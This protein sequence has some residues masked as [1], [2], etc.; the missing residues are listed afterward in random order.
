[1]P[2]TDSRQAR[3]GPEDPEGLSADFLIEGHSAV[4]AILAG[5]C[6][7]RERLSLYAAPENR[8]FAITRILRVDDAEVEIDL[9]GQDEFA[10][11]LARGGQ[12]IGVAFPGQIKIQ[13]SLDE[14]SVLSADG[15]GGP[16]LRAPL[17]V[18]LHRFQRRDAFRVRPPV[19]DEARCVRILGPDREASHPICDIS[20]GGLSILLDEGIAAP[21]LGAVWEHC[22][23]EAGQDPAIPCELVVTR[24]TPIEGRGHRIGL[25]FGKMPSEALRLI[26]ML[27]I[28]TEKRLRPN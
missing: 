28:R 19:A 10:R 26:Q 16:L 25:S 22:R 21:Q 8:D 14:F 4:R 27:V 24:I 13:F 5:L 1:M 20:A 12:A 2:Q 9:A 15:S 17:P 6:D 11:L 18:R 23:I 7:R 3:A